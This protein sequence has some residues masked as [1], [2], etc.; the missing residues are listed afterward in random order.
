M[1]LFWLI[2]LS[3]VFA[4]ILC[5][6]YTAYAG[7]FKQ[8][9]KNAKQLYKVDIMYEPM[10]WLIVAFSVALSWLYVGLF[11]FGRLIRMIK[12]K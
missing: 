7:E 1:F 11:V 5:Y 10:F 9:R 4:S 12:L 3:G 2:Y 8:V 6:A